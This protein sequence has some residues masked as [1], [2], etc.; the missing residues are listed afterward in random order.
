MGLLF[1]ARICSCSSFLPT[2]K[3][4]K[5]WSD[6]VATLE[7]VSYSFGLVLTLNDNPTRHVFEVHFSSLCNQKPAFYG[8]LNVPQ[9]P[10]S[11]TGTGQEYANYL[12]LQLPQ[13]RD[14][15]ILLKKPPCALCRYAKIQASGHPAPP[16]SLIRIF[17][18]QYHSTDPVKFK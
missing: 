3:G 8:N 11:P 15:K 5:K 6:R 12:S 17:S 18:I 9:T 7:S 10:V 4:E 14:F 1:K 13:Y 2:D 16:S